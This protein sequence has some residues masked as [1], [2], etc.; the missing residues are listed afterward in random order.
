MNND[1]KR[2]ID[3]ALDY[4]PNLLLALVVLAVGL[5]I[6]GKIKN[7]LKKAIAKKFEEDLVPVLT[8]LII[9][10]LKVLLFFSVAELVGIKTTSFVALLAAAGFAIGMALQGSLSNFASGVLVLLFKPYKVGDLIELEDSRGWVEEIQIFNTILKTVTNQKIIIPN[11]KATDGK[12]INHSANGYIRL[13][14]FNA[15]PYQE[16]FNR[17]E[18]AIL[19]EI[20]GIPGILDKPEP[21]VG[22]EEFDSH[23]IKIGTFLFVEPENY[24]DVYYDV[25]KA[26]KIALGKNHIQMA[27]SEGVELGPIGVN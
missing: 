15:I 19:N 3:A 24:W 27:Y 12:I 6:I 17:A 22:I 9:V 18:E 8:S 23:N 25:H 2:I 14:L 11:A 7:R 21:S 13:D 20:K 26:I 5:W 1:F 4:S 16:D 10:L